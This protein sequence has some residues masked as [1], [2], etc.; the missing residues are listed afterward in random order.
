MG[1]NEELLKLVSQS[2]KGSLTICAGPGPET[3][4]ARPDNA[5]QIG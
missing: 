4:R 1:K 5:M 3:R 2:F